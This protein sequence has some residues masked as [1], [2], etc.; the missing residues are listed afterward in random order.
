MQLRSI[1][2]DDQSADELF[3]LRGHPVHTNGN[4]FITHGLKAAYYK[5]TTI[6]VAELM[7]TP[8][9]EADKEQTVGTLSFEVSSCSPVGTFPDPDPT[10]DPSAGYWRGL[11][12]VKRQV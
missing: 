10:Y 4:E 12:R 11:V 6:P 3:R 5:A 9:T 2:G 8:P 1:L 7:A